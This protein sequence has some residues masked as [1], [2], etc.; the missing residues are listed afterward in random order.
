MQAAS[1]RV[2]LLEAP[3]LV[4]PRAQS[5][6]PQRRFRLA[7]VLAL[8]P[9]GLS[10]DEVA[11]LF[12][13]DR[14]Q[15]AAR[16]NLRKL[17]LELKALEL[18]ALQ[19][20]GDRLAWPV[21]SDALDLLEGRGPSRRWS[22]PLP[23]LGGHDS[24]AF[25]EWLLVQRLR[26]FDAW[27]ARQRCLAAAD[28]A[29][30]ALDAAEALL[31]Q[32]PDDA[33][34]LRRAAVARRGLGI[35]REAAPRGRRHDDV[36]GDEPGLIGRGVELAELQALLGERRCRLLTLLGPGGVGKSALALALLQD[37][38]VPQADV[39]HWVALEDLHDV[40]GVPLR[41]ARELGAR[42][43]PRSDGFDECVAAL[44]D[45]QALLILDNAE[46][47]PA[48]P[49]LADRLLASLPL[50][51]L[52][53][54]SRQRLG[55]GA[56]W[57][58]P[59][60]PLQ[61]AA[62]QRLFVDAARRAPAR[63]PLDAADPAVEALAELLGRLPLAL[64]L[65]AAWTRHLPPAALVQ[66]LRQSIQLLQAQ[67]SVDEHP[68]H[69]SLQ[70]TFDHSWAL[71]DTAL[72]P[73]LAALSVGDGSMPM[74]V[75]MA[76]ADASAAQLAALADAS[77]IDLEPNGRVSM[78]PLLRRYA[79]AR[80]A[81]DAE[82]SRASHERHAQA[83]ADLLRPVTDF[84]SVDVDQALA[85]IAPERQQ[86]E[87][88]W[89]TA[90]ARQR[91]EWLQVYA[92]AL[93]ALA[94]AQGGVDGV[95]H[96]FSEAV[97]ALSGWRS[98]PPAAR[99]DVMLEHAALHFWRGEHDP[100]EASARVALA[101]ARAAR[102]ERPMS[103][104]LNLMA[105]VA[106][107]RGHTAR[108]ATLMERALAFAQR[109][110][111]RGQV[112]IL[113]GNLSGIWRELGHL[114]RAHANAVQAL[115]L[116]RDRQYAIGEV[117]MLAELSQLAQ[118]HGRADEAGD[119]IARALQLSQRHAMALRHASL[120]TF[121]VGIR[122]DQGR[123]DD[124]QALAAEALAAMQALAGRHYHESTLRRLLAEL[125]LARGDVTEARAQLRRACALVAP[126]AQEVN[127]RGLLWSLALLAAFTGDAALAAALA[128]RAERDRPPRAQ[129]LP[130]YAAQRE[131][132]PA[133]PD[134]LPPDAALQ[135]AIDTLLG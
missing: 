133:P 3:A 30:Q 121:Q 53:V 88:A 95:L 92:P 91:A 55:L 65:A 127:A 90:V 77:L 15:A 32:V 12:W 42:V 69:H 37:G 64:R 105:L 74:P 18:P 101:I 67:E 106:L 44:H 107:R 24:P 10:R 109:A 7:A 41:I 28:D 1:P 122:L 80:L 98:A 132:W 99:A 85:T 130:R 14:P 20:D 89:S 72:R 116:H 2:R 75:A 125:A 63:R 68:A 93:S 114:D 123:L 43:G 131:R 26:L 39:V 86:I 129:P 128:R 79:R 126:L 58:M 9:T 66:Q 115:Q 16:S 34:A 11:A 96:L 119:W 62:A 104:A 22:E 52:L 76:T 36:A 5:F 35:D 13:P 124:A 45:R 83:L 134:P 111:P 70:A 40:A 51:R 21:D 120:L 6:A 102:L 82:A 19:L 4:A 38:A 87:H 113:A 25:D 73:V 81:A 17:I 112:A 48:L 84:D 117:A 97:P 94:Q 29:R 27:Q 56:E 47:L 61:P 57:V 33:D 78:H 71:L 103:Q 100:C 118:L 46:H 49:A 135:R 23:G 54:T 59:L 8:S 110:A 108:A 60:A 31:A 50:L